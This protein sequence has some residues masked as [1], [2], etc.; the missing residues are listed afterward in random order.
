VDVLVEITKKVN[1]LEDEN[2]RCMKR[3]K[4]LENENDNC[5]EKG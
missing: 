2:D 1:D 5:M 3:I 4:E